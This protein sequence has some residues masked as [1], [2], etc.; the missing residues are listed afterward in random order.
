MST[1]QACVLFSFPEQPYF[2]QVSAWKSNYPS[3]LLLIVI[4]LLKFSSILPVTA[5][6]KSINSSSNSPILWKPLEKESVF[7][8]IFNTI[9]RHYHFCQAQRI[10][11][12]GETSELS[13]NKVYTK[14]SGPLSD[15]VCH[16]PGALL[17][18][19]IR[20]VFRHLL[21]KLY[22]VVDH[23]VGS[24]NGAAGTYHG[25]RITPREKEECR[26]T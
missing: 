8:N 9:H 14:S 1:A 23:E 12:R 16:D 19:I 2:D 25:P 20:K 10:V 7:S 18:D 26:P 21:T 6:F 17:F 22:R 5:P 11:E 3:V 24:Y 15:L 13:P 4:L